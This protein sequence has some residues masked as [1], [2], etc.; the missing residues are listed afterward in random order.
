M[1]RL[2]I[3]LVVLALVLVV[4]DRAGAALASRAVASQVAATGEVSG[5]P[6]VSIKGFPFLT[7]ALSGRYADIEVSGTGLVKDQGVSEFDAQLSGVHLPL[8]EALSG[9]VSAVPVDRVDATVLL[10]YAELERRLAN[11]RLT[12]SAAGDLLRVTG[13]VTV[14]GRTLSAS[15]LSAVRVDGRAVVVT[16][17]RFEVGSKP[18]DKV[19]SAALGSRLDFRVTLGALPYGLVLQ[20]V[21]VE[22][23]GVRARATAESAVLTR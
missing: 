5:D 16:A 19:L 1:R 6:S 3:T 13:S 7:Q 2:L 14:L 21:R 20:S 8:A 12:L 9:R 15:A 10:P 17:Q 11:R 22:P 23:A 18:A 4:V